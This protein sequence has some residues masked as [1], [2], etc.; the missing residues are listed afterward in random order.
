LAAPRPYVLATLG[1]S[2]LG[3]IMSTNGGQQHGG[4]APQ[5]HVLAQYTKDFSRRLAGGAS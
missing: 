4:L 1:P 5:L 3:D 2:K